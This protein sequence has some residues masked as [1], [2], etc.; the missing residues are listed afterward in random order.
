MSSDT[1][2]ASAAD[3]TAAISVSRL[4][5]D[6]GATRA[7]DQLDMTVRSGEVHGFLGPNGGQ[8][9]HDSDSSRSGFARA[10][11]R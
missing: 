1:M 5:K 7:L 10:A 2:A 9:H 3:A 11:G 4:V 6:F 8:D